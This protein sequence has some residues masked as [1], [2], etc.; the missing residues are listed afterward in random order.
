MRA[1]AVVAQA[2]ALVAIVRVLRQDIT[3]D[4]SSCM[5]AV[6]ACCAVTAAAR[7]A[8]VRRQRA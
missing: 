1:T 8:L 2:L 7:R 5:R 4:A 3:M 6:T